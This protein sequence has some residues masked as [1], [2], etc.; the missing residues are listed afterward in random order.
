MKPVNRK[1]EILEVAAKLF[2][3]KGY[4][5]VSVRD[6]ANILNIKAASLYYHVT[7]KQEI[8]SSIVI[9]VAEE[10]IAGMNEIL[11]EETSAV[12]KIEK[13]IELHVAITADRTD[14]LAC[15]N[16]DWMHL[17]GESLD[18][19]Q[20]MRE[21]YEDHIRKILQAGIDEG[22]IEELN[23]EV[24]LFSLLTSL[25]RVYLW[26]PRLGKL[27]REALSEQLKQSLLRGV[28][29]GN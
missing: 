17:E 15:L 26:Y 4:T 22:E 8:L 18:Y 11:V 9:Q 27:S 12:Q 28:L 24:L 20:K 5:A 29:K 14:F 23:I 13:F 19:F 16:N 25:R 21:S 1:E 2:K 3:E 7:S 10:F 6:I